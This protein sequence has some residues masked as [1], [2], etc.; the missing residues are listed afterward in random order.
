MRTSYRARLLRIGLLF[1]A[2]GLALALSET[3]LGA[4]GYPT[5]VPD[6]VAHPPHFKEVRRS[7]EFH[8]TFQ[9]NERGLRYRTLPEAIPADGRRIFVC[10]DS[11]V[12]GT[13][14]EEGERFTDLLEARFG[15]STN[16][17]YFINGGLAGTGPYEYA[18]VFLGVGL[19]YHPDSLL[20]CLYANDVANTFAGEGSD[21]FESPPPRSGFRKAVHRI[22]PRIYTL[23]KSAQWRRQYARQTRTTDFMETVRQKAA[24]RGVPKARIDAWTATVPPLLVAAVN[25][26]EFNGTILSNGLL[27]PECWTDSIDVNSDAANDKWRNMT[28]ILTGLTARCREAGISVALVYI[29]SDLQYDPASHAA[30]NLWTLTGTTVRAEWLSGTTEVQRR[31]A[32]WAAQ[33]RLPYLDLTPACREAVYKGQHLTWPMDGHWTREGHALAAHEIGAWLHD[34]GVSMAGRP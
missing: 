32:A 8:Y 24:E 27:Y 11:F 7:L 30:G 26:G 12:E 31:L 19:Q 29:P 16:R 28:R 9:T 4:L 5:E 21:P 13:G 14:V 20:I 22:A 1:V 2:L 17:I 3:L 18:R 25:R 33:L 15:S 6:R 34:S 10:G 23:M